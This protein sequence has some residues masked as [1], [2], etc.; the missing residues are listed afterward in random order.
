MR[1]P[2]FEKRGRGEG[3]FCVSI[4][5]SQAKSWS[6]G[7]F[8][9]FLR[10]L[11]ICLLLFLLIFLLFHSYKKF[12]SSF[13]SFFICSFILACFYLSWKASISSCFLSELSP[14]ARR[15]SVL[16]KFTA[17]YADTAIKFRSTHCMYEYDLLVQSV[18]Y[19]RCSAQLFRIYSL[20]YT[21]PMN[22]KNTPSEFHNIPIPLSSHWSIELAWQLRYW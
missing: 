3:F 19:H 17:W 22:S 14:S 9:F 10:R 16:L 4:G 8:I 11:E 13:C 6:C 20:L 2:R 7:Q 21:P 18:D 12:Y 1:P 15:T 5:S